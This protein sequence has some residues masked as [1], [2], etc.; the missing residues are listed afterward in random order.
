MTY[1]RD[2]EP[3]LSCA[4]ICAAV[5]CESQWKHKQGCR[6]FTAARVQV[7]RTSQDR[8]AQYQKVTDERKHPI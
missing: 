2:V 5:A 7:V 8:A 3:D 4:E 1:I 6:L